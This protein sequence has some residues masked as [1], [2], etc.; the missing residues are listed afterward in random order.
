MNPRE[1]IEAQM[2]FQ[3]VDHIPLLGGWFTSASQYQ[4]FAQVSEKEFLNNPE[5]IAIHAYK[6][7]QID[8]LVEIALPDHYNCRVTKEDKEK[9]K[10]TYPT[11]ESIIEY[12]D[13]LPP[14][15]TIADTFD[16]EAFYKLI[17]ETMKK[18]QRMGQMVFMPARW[19]CAGNFMGYEK[20]G[21]ENY[22]MALA[23]AP[24]K[25]RKFF[26]YAA[27]ESRL[28]N[29]VLAKVH[30]DYNFCK[31]LLIGQ[32]ICDQSGPMVSVKFLEENYFPSVKYALKPLINGGFKLIW[33]SD[34]NIMSI[35][36][37]II[38]LGV[39]GFQGFQWE[40]GTTIEKIA[41][42]NTRDG[43]KLIFFT[44]MNVIRTLTFGTIDDVRREIDHCFDV[45]GGR[46]LFIFPSNTI[47][48]DA[49]LENIKA[50]YEYSL[51]LNP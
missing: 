36:D 38:D 26:E 3:P 46:G 8:G 37:L 18:Q 19:F 22:F 44:G 30:K 4:Y 42:R 50:A 32:D 17:V 2:N 24:G 47:N 28:Q 10:I 6:N 41:K 25:M 15:E 39:A 14:V 21:N 45:T 13:G 48:P 35:V 31:L 11:P 51:V 40:T 27:E 43:Q 49:K 7:L 23:L 20:F 33:H 5:D 12:V 34:G 1:R 9:K 16:S 29:E